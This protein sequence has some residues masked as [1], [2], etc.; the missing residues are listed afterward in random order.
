MSFQ[1]RSKMFK[2]EFRVALST[3]VIC[4]V[5]GMQRVSNVQEVHPIASWSVGIEIE[6]I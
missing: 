4:S 6:K 1:T 3:K 5:I 2:R